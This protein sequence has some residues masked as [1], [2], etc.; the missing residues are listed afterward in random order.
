LTISSV[1]AGGG[2]GRVPAAASMKPDKRLS[3][4]R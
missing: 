2:D 3:S 4:V 1:V